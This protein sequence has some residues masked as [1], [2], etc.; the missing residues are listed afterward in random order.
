MTATTADVESEDSG[1][2]EATPVEV[3]TRT[4]DSQSHDV[5]T[6]SLNVM[7]DKVIADSLVERIL[8]TRIIRGQRFYRVK[9]ARAGKPCEWVAAKDIP[10]IMIGHFHKRYTLTGRKR[11]TNSRWKGLI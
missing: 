10:E 3:A 8:K 4:N 11:R 7:D 5:G 6:E 1:D 2:R 9:W